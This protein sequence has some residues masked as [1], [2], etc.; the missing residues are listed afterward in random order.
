M[1]T[2]LSLACLTAA[3]ALTTS[4][5]A[6]DEAGFKPL[7]DGK[8]LNGWVG[9]PRFWSVE[10]G[11]IVGSTDQNKAPHNTF[12]AT[13]KSY[14]NFVIK[15]EFK[16]RNHNSGIQVRSK[17]LPEFVVQGYQPDIAEARYT[18]NLYEERGRGT[19]VQ[20]DVAE[21]KKF[22]TPGQWAEYTITCDG[23]N[24]TL[25]LNG[26]VTVRYTEKDPKKGATDG[27]IALQLH[28]G[29]KM[30]VW[31]RNIRIKELP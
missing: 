5:R 16:L 22:Y 30:K 26:H 3:L 10:D 23:P 31:F 21:V 6:G 28:A 25:A 18:G 24:L 29:P 11:T 2:L 9:D 15:A 7:F 12:L 1:R 13:T 27:I 8:T 4:A 20:V 17:L 19:L 14:K